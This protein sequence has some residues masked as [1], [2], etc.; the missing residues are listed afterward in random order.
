MQKGE[1]NMQ[2]IVN[3]Q[4]MPFAGGSLDSLLGHLGLE[5]KSVVAEVNG[6]I[7][8]QADFSGQELRDGDIVE[9]VRFVGGG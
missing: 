6:V 7:V 5:Q 2:I 1:Q 4:V 8:A 9:L 3:G